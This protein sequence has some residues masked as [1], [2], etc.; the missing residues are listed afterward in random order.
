MN[1]VSKSIVLSLIFIC[2]E[3]PAFSIQVV[4]EA[5]SPTNGG[6]AT[7]IVERG[8]TVDTVSS[9]KKTIAID[10]RS[11]TLAAAPVVVHSASGKDIQGVGSIR[12]GTKVRFNTTKNNYAAQEQIVEI[13]IS[14]T[15]KASK[16]K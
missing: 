11:Y 15:I 3:Q 6:V 8:G 4:N 14:E 9:E 16:A 12:P 1:L 2:L 5:R 10:G 13:W 7:K